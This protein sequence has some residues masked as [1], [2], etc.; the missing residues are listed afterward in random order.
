MEENII[1]KLKNEL[2]NSTDGIKIKVKV[3]ANAKFNSIEKFDE[4]ILKIKINKP[5]IDG[6]AN[7]A[8]IEYLSEIF[9]IP[10]TNIIILKG[11]KNNLK[12]LKI[13]PKKHIIT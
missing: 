7:K 4:E 9:E 1:D 10:K 12:D 2:L 8:I 6:K 13:V 11:E 5:A 3:I